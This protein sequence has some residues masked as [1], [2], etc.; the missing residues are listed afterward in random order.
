MI[1]YRSSSP[2]DVPS[3]KLNKEESVGVKFT[4]GSGADQCSVPYRYVQGTVIHTYAV[5]VLAQS[6]TSP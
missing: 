5:I 3:P 6:C 1:H 4:I 2:S